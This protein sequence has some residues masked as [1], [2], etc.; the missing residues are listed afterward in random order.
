VVGAWVSFGGKH[1]A[2]I[3]TNG[4]QFW[5]QYLN[6]LVIEPQRVGQGKGGLPRF[7]ET[8]ADAKA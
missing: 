7:L 8:N 5:F 6:A 3:W 4:A 2:A 1:W